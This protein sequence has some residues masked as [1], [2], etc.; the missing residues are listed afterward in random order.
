MYKIPVSLSYE[1]ELG[2]EYERDST[3][4]AVVYAPPQ[5]MVSIDR[6]EVLT[7]GRQ[8][9]VFIAFTNRGLSDIKR[10]SA[11][12]SDGAGF[13]VLSTAENYLGD[14]DS[15]DF[16]TVEV[17]LFVTSIGGS[18]KIPVEYSFLDEFNNV[19]TRSELVEARVY[20]AEE[21]T[22]L[23]LGAA[24]GG[25]NNILFGLG[26]VVVIYLVY[27]QFLRRKKRE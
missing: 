17:T 20:T 2:N 12:V 8:G 23:Q 19:N 6:S 24:T 21:I 3:V 18:I 16:E 10:L 25:L 14:I 13:Q 27:R 7:A 22:A 9:K 11:K 4:S 5:V 26:A 1:D 15:D